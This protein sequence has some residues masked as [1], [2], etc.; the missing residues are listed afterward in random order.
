MSPLPVYLIIHT[1][2]RNPQDGVQVFSD[3]T[4]VDI[5]YCK[6]VFELTG[7]VVNTFDEAST[8]LHEFHRRL[9]SWKTHT[10]VYILKGTLV[11]A[12]G[13]INPP[14]NICPHCQHKPFHGFDRDPIDPETGVIDFVECNHCG[15]S[16]SENYAR[17]G[18][19]GHLET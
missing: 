18:S 12:H 14:P 7:I 2:G 5:A 11:H 6:S 17:N 4:L 13:F 8:A 19:F 9:P 3:R 16:W 10:D 15:E 1:D